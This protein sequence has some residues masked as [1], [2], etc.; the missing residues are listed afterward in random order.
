VDEGGDQ[1]CGDDNIPVFLVVE[2][3][4]ISSAALK[5]SFPSATNRRVTIF[6]F[7]SLLCCLAMQGEKLISIT[8]FLFSSPLDTSNHQLVY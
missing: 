1:E 3:W 7:A 5:H 6:L 4:I 8:T 2:I